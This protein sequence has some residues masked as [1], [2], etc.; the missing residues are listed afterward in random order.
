MVVNNR[1]PIQDPFTETSMFRSFI[2]YVRRDL[3]LAFRRRQDLV[4][5]LLFFVVVVTLFPLGVSPERA[6]LSEAAAGVIWVA[7]LLATMLSLDSLFRADYEDGTLEQMIL[8]PHPLFLLVIAKV[9]AHW[10]VSAIPLLILTPLLAVMMHMPAELIPTLLLSLLLGSPVLSMVG[11]IGAALTLGLRQG[12]VLLALLILPLYIPVLIFG[13][14]V[15][16]AAGSGLATGGFF[17]IQGAL[18][19]LAVTLA[20]FA[21]AAALRIGVSAG[22]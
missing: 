20:P 12:G 19:A 22:G 9:L 5:P 15:V 6:F 2:H 17:A 8:T 18:L 4:T 1:M 10:L 14:G 13:T 3:V 16:E 11:A 7:A 21:A